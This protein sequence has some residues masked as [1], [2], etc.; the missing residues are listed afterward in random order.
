MNKF[1]SL[2]VLKRDTHTGAQINDLRKNGYVP[3]VIYGAG[4]DPEKV[5][6]NEITL[7]KVMEKG[8]ALSK[9]FLVTDGA[10]SETAIIR[11][12][13]FHPITC[14]PQHV[15]FMRV[16]KGHT[17]N[18]RVPVTC[19]NH[20]SSPAI[21][22]GGVLNIVIRE[23]D[24]AC[25]VENIPAAINVDLTGMDFHHTIKLSDLVLPPNCHLMTQMPLNSAVI[26]VV[27]PSGLR[28]EINKSINEADDKAAAA[29]E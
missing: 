25:D 19:C 5:S 2:E 21:K 26:T 15:D 13:Q 7:V 24:V 6:I 4:K 14:R 23:I 11:D 18:I 22:K 8:S 12:V 29:T 10:N 1:D 17:V 16:A 9:I 28:S 27:A 3:G 20:E